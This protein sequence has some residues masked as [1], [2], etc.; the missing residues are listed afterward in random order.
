MYS[1][2]TVNTHFYEARAS[3]NFMQALRFS[4]NFSVSF[5][6]YTLLYTTDYSTHMFTSAGGVVE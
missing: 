4:C 5:V 2:V 6:T 3:L 1:L